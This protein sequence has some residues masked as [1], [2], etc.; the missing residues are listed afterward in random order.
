M[1]LQPVQARVVQRAPVAPHPHADLVDRNLEVVQL[2]WHREALHVVRRVDVVLP[3]GDAH[4]GRIERGGGAIVRDCARREGGLR[5]QGG[6]RHGGVDDAH[7]RLHVG[8][9][10]PQLDVLGGGAD[11]EGGALGDV[12]D[13]EVGGDDFA[14]QQDRELGSTA[15]GRRAPAVADVA[16]REDG[17]D[18]VWG[19]EFVG[20]D[21]EPGAR[22]DGQFP[23][24]RCQVRVDGGAE[25]AGEVVDAVGADELGDL[26][27]ERV[28]GVLYGGKAGV[29]IAVL[30][31]IEGGT[32]PGSD[33]PSVDW[34]QP[35]CL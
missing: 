32:G 1:H 7:A 16:P 21:A 14:G 4:P 18:G 10:H 6:H 15:G 25:A 26:R 31:T 13:D 19:A 27:R 24:R 28:V 35:S 20:G 9:L 8:D 11:V 22:T 29:D 34:F 30:V 3:A 23:G 17:G 33:V 5:R 12:F 2:E